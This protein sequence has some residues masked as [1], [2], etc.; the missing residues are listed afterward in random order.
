MSKWDELSLR[1]KSEMM[2]VAVRNGIYRLDD[3]R[4]KY[5]EFAEG[6]STSDDDLVD[7]I[8]QE[9]GFNAKS[10]DIGDGKTTLGSGLTASKWHELYKKRG[11]KWSAA[12]NRRAVSEEVASRRRWAERNVPNWDTLPE[13]AQKALLSYKYNFDFNRSN[14]PKLFTA[15]EAGN[16]NE[17]ARQMNATSRDPKFRKGLAGRRRREQ[18][19]F[20]SDVW[21]VPKV[22]ETFIVPAVSTAVYNPYR[23][24]AEATQMMPFTIPSDYVQTREVS[25]SEQRAE[26]IKERFDAINNFNRVMNLFGIENTAI[27]EFDG[28]L[29]TLGILTGK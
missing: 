23:Q 5:N 18:E 19:W 26:K 10:E 11:N 15:L 6:G 7:F 22:D 21:N 14:S 2:S 4:N 25:P 29:G 13:S 17:A 27:P 24:Q 9:E 16:L 1:E 12:D 8:I 3:I 20:L 28:F